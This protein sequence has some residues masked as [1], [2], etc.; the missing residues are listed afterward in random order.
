MRGHCDTKRVRQE[1]YHEYTHWGTY[2]NITLASR[3]RARRF[4][5]GQR[6]RG[7]RSFDSC[8]ELPGQALTVKMPS[9]NLRT[10]TMITS[11]YTTYSPHAHLEL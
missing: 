8:T 3:A 5:L 1:W 2:Q 6:T 9:C 4:C 7:Q 10:I 11:A